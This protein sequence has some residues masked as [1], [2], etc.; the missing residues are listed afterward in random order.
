MISYYGT[1]SFEREGILN[2]GLFKALKE[3][4]SN[5]GMQLTKAVA[6]GSA[7][8]Y[9]ADEGK[10]IMNIPLG[11]GETIVLNGDDVLAFE[12]SVKW[13]IKRNTSI[14]TVLTHGMTNL[15]LTGPGW[16]AITTHG[17]PVI[18]HVT[19]DSVVKTDPQNTVA[20]SGGLTCSF[21]VDLKLKNLVG[22]GSG[23]ESQMTFT[24]NGFV[25]IQPIQEFDNRTK[26][27]K[28]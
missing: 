14:S 13:D 27:Q 25:V 1:I 20:W 4:V 11:K 24:G 12:S 23:E 5:E 2:G 10:C 28:D 16:V 9:I 6:K 8:M 21:K 22:R 18:L 26:K 7:L 19:K 3:S 17:D 15:H